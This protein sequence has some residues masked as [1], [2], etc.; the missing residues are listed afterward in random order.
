MTPIIPPELWDYIIDYLHDDMH[1]LGACCLVCRSW[2]LSSRFHLFATVQLYAFDIDTYLVAICAPGST[3]PPYV[4]NLEVYNGRNEWESTV[5]IN[6]LPKLPQ[7]SAV[8]RLSLVHVAWDTLIP[9]AKERLFGLSRGLKALKLDHM[10]FLSIGQALHFISSAPLLEALSLGSVYFLSSEVLLADFPAPPVKR[11]IFDVNVHL[12][13]IIDWLCLWQPVPTVR[14]VR[15]DVF[16]LEQI[17][18]I[19]DYLRRLGPL[20][21]YLGLDFEHR[22]ELPGIPV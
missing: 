18:C 10:D 4:R 9:E 15:F 5:V 14:S 6:A 1:T 8:E 22:G 20:L 16:K 13:V 12:P 17:P 7:L 11:I 3:I 2:L 19:S 21:E